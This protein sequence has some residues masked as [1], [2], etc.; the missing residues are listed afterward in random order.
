M[1]DREEIDIILA[2][3][4]NTPTPDTLKERV[5]LQKWAIDQIISLIVAD[6]QAVELLTLEEWDEALCS[7]PRLEMEDV[8][9]KK[10]IEQSRKTQIAI[11]E[12]QASKM[13]EGDKTTKWVKVKK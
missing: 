1:I 5:A 11:C 6:D 3:Y 10:L 2:R 4:H 9:D 7:V 13:I 12:A 8:T